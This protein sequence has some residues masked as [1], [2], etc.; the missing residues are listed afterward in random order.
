MG[1]RAEEPE[2]P[3][4]AEAAKPSCLSVRVVNQGPEANGTYSTTTKMITSVMRGSASTIRAKRA[5][6]FK[7][8]DNK[9]WSIQRDN[10]TFRKKSA[11]KAQWTLKNKDGDVLTNLVVLDPSADL[12][13]GTNLPGWL[14]PVE[15]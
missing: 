11:T 9:G 3:K 2:T 7:C 14:A 1:K 10:R 13:A 5:V 6:T 15:N 4:A 8:P 12:L